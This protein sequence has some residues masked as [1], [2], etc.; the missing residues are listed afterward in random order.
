[1]LAAGDIEAELAV[2][3]AHRRQYLA[4]LGILD[5]DVYLALQPVVGGSD[6]A[7]YRI[8]FDGV[9]RI[10]GAVN[11]V[12]MVGADYSSADC[13]NEAAAMVRDALAAIAARSS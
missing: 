10:A 9:C 1:M 11:V 8:S 6:I 5:G 3:I 4:V 13:R 2:R 12:G 7:R